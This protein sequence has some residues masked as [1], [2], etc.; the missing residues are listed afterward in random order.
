MV[1]RFFKYILLYRKSLSHCG[2]YY[3]SIVYIPLQYTFEI[4]KLD[5]KVILYQFFINRISST[6]YNK[7]IDSLIDN[8]IDIDDYPCCCCHSCSI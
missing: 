5:E 2:G 1:Y 7:T 6:E 8:I 4:S 3:P